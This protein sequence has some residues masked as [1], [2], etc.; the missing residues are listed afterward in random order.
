MKES[1]KE[2]KLSLR[3]LFEPCILLLLHTEPTYGYELLNKIRKLGISAEDITLLYRKL[4]RLERTELVVSYWETEENERPR[5]IYQLTEKG[6]RYL[7]DSISEM[8]SLLKN[9]EKLLN[10][11]LK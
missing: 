6:E 1:R 11:F 9:I 10:E 5:K 4:H 3:D 7:K 2:G 8:E